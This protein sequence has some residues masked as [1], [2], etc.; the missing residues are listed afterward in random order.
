M[1]ARVFLDEFRPFRRGEIALA[2]RATA[3]PDFLGKRDLECLRYV[4]RFA[5][6]SSIGAE[7]DQLVDRIGTERLRILQLMAP[8]LPVDPNRI[9]PAALAKRLP[10]VWA[11]VA[12][13]R[14][15]LIE[16]GVCNESDLDAEV[17][18][19]RLV[20]VLGGAAGSGYVFLGALMRLE[21]LGVRKAAISRRGLGGIQG[22]RGEAIQSSINGE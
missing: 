16:G 21:A 20:L 12:S 18:D 11:L 2:R 15:K 19:K 9:D 8:V 7:P 3:E 17:A 14:G 13:A 22:P 5:Q 6:L 10:K 4:L 1:D